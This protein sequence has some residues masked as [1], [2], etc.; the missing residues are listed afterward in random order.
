MSDI[1]AVLFFLALVV[2][3]IWLITWL[4]AFALGLSMLKA[5]ALAVAIAMVAGGS[6]R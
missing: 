6:S 1:L 2:G 3:L 4:F 5:F